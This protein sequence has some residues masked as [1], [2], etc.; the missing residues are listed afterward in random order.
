MWNLSA[1]GISSNKLSIEIKS[2]ICKNDFS[3]LKLNQNR[4]NRDEF[5]VFWSHIAILA[6]ATDQWSYDQSN[7]NRVKRICICM[8]YIY[9]HFVCLSVCVCSARQVLS[10]KL[11]DNWTNHVLYYSNEAVPKTKSFQFWEIFTLY[12]ISAYFV[13]SKSK[14]AKENMYTTHIRRICV[15]IKRMIMMCVWVCVYNVH[16][17][18]KWYIKIVFVTALFPSLF[19]LKSIVQF[20]F[21]PFCITCV[22]CMQCVCVFFARASRLFIVIHCYYCCC[23]F[24]LH[25]TQSTLGMLIHRIT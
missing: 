15:Y 19:F 14:I 17:T 10:F 22:R 16:Y 7:C 3:G 20:P 13:H 25:F 6:C 11:I 2:C 12:I 23:S 21:F 18:I 4:A 1:I 9:L 5:V 24:E 8:L